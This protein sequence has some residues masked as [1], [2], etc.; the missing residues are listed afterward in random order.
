MFIVPA[1]IIT[2]D[3]ATYLRY[4]RYDNLV[5]LGNEINY[6]D[7]FSSYLSAGIFKTEGLQNIADRLGFLDFTVESITSSNLYKPILNQYIIL[8]VLLIILR[9]ELSYLAHQFQVK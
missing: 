8:R 3:L 7:L 9:L 5:V 6:L 2:Y 1:S 4:F